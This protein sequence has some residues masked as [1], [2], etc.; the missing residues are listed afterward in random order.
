[1]SSNIYDILNKFQ[2]LDSKPDPKVEQQPKAKTRLQESIDTVSEK[3]MG[4]KKVA[5]AAKAGGAKDP[6]AVA[7]AI[8]RKKY[9]KEKFQKAAAKGKKLGEEQGVAEG[10]GD[11]SFEDMNRAEL[12]D[13]L[14]MSPREAAD[15]TNKDLRD[16]CEEKTK[17]VSEVA[18][19]G[20]KAERMVKHIKKGYAKDGKLTDKE[21]SIAYA[22]AWKAHKAGKVEEA[23]Q[24]LQ[25]LVA[26]GM[27][28]EQITEGWDDMLK[29]VE[30]KHKEQKDKEGTGKFDKT[31]I[32]TGT[33]YTRKYDADGM[34]NTDDEVKPEGEKRKRGR[35]K[36]SA[37]ESKST[38][39]KMIAEAYTAEGGPQLVDIPAYQRKAAGQNF[40]LKVADLEPKGVI[41]SKQGL[42]DLKNQLGMKEEEHEVSAREPEDMK[43]DSQ[44]SY[45]QDLLKKGVGD[46]MYNELE[47]AMQDP[48]FD[49]T[50]NEPLYNALYDYYTDNN[51]MPYDVAKARTGTPDEWI[52]NKMQELFGSTDQ[53]Q[54]GPEDN[55]M[56]KELAEMMR[57]AGMPVNEQSSNDAK[58]VSKGVWAIASMGGGDAGYEWLDR[59]NDPIGDA[60]RGYFESNVSDKMD[61]DQYLAQNVDPKVLAQYA[62][63]V[64]GWVNDARFDLSETKMSE[65][66]MEEGNEFTAARVAAIKA[67]KDSFTVDGK[68]YKVTGD[69][70]D[71]KKMEEA[72]TEGEECPKCHCDPCECDDKEKVD[73]RV[74]VKPDGTTTQSFAQ[75]MAAKSAEQ[76]PQGFIDGDEEV[77]ECG[78]GYEMDQGQEGRMNVSTNMSSDGNKSVTISAEGEAAEELMQML[79]L[80]GMKAKQPMPQEENV[81]QQMAAVEEE[82]DPRYQASTTPEEEVMPVQVQTKGGNGEVA[83]KEK[84]MHKD[85]AARFSDNPLAMKE[86]MD[87]LGNMGRDLMKQYNSIKVQK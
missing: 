21:R 26:A 61:F 42:A 58:K 49:L 23:T 14:N 19:P 6:D 16:A 20:A 40:P 5:A 22:T 80:A 47:A 33:V 59:W 17:D 83:G 79:A 18:P 55:N 70:S 69:T 53:E 30:K 75:Q 35:P 44:L 28:A 37:F 54:Q 38:A 2:S 86:S 71:E 76:E 43:E 10:S 81:H 62:S 63:D 48:N 66:D 34:S 45:E 77:K 52:M 65:A 7:A 85:G 36:K 51:E 57:L 73:E 41:S 1:M 8:G 25:T 24:A 67:G 9:G 39:E 12:L 87:D 56:D 72:V 27:T 3:Y 31:K 68:T 4:F 60:W 32:S 46:Q 78:P 84:A 64:N 82:K 11:K 13:Y 50:A 15:M 74:M 29:A